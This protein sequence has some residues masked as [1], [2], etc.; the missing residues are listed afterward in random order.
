MDTEKTDSINAQEPGREIEEYRT[1]YTPEDKLQVEVV[2]IREEV[3][4]MK[5]PYLQP[6][7]WIGVVALTVSVASNIVQWMASSNEAK[8]YES[9]VIIAKADLIKAET[10]KKEAESALQD[11]ETATRNIIASRD[12]AKNEF[13]SLQTELAA[14]KTGINNAQQTST[15]E[16]VKTSLGKVEKKVASLERSTEKAVITL[17]KAAPVSNLQTAITSEREG[18]QH[19]INGSYGEAAA[20]F[21]A[22]EDAYPTF[23]NA[24]ELAKILKDNQSKMSNPATKKEVFQTIVNKFSYG[25]PPDLWKRVVQIAGE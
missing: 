23:H 24:H 25:A 21:Q 1:K 19:L 12:Q 11:A 4:L 13:N 9:K 5:K 3:R 22:A 8:V 6:T 15:S 2:K 18:F 20:A 14:I 7:F 16:E 10:A 17:N